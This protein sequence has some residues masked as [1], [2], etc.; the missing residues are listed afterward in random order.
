MKKESSP[1]FLNSVSHC[2]LVELATVCRDDRK[3]GLGFGKPGIGKT[4]SAKKFCNWSLIEAN[5]AAKGGVVVE[6][7]N[8]LACDSAYYMP[9]VTVTAARLKIELNQLKNKFEDTYLKAVNW[10]RPADW[11]KE[12]QN[13]HLKLI[14]VDEAFRL[15]Y[16]ALE[17]LR[18]IQEEWDIGVLLIADPGFERA[19]SRMWHFSVRVAHVEELKPLSEEET[20]QFID[21]Q[22]EIM[23]LPKPPEEVYKLIHWYTQG[24][25]RGLVN[26]F[27]MIARIL[28]INEDVV[29]EVTREVVE[30]ARE[31][32]IFGKHGSLSKQVPLLASET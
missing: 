10:Q 24:V 29:R 22:L 30:A 17:Q 13:Q 2:D 4:F 9:S 1:I 32:M 8:M 11:A 15:K 18:D 5:L 31:M 21:K 27:S 14:V 7:E 26:L 23:G 3:I 6:P 28:K 19:L 16:Q 20:N 12:I 25:L